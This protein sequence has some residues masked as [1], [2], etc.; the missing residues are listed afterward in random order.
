MTKSTKFL[1]VALVA[2]LA[3]SAAHAWPEGHSFILVDGD[4]FEIECI[5]VTHNGGVAHLYWTDM[6][7]ALTL[8]QEHPGAGRTS[9]TF[10]LHG[11]KFGDLYMA[12]KTFVDCT[13]S[14]FGHPRFKI[15][16]FPEG[17]GTCTCTATYRGLNL[18]KK[19][20]TEPLMGIELGGGATCQKA[21]A[22]PVL[23]PRV[24]DQWNQANPA[25]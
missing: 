20:R 9:L 25:R 14:R 23:R 6:A 11:K 5:D 7:T 8:Q 19:A 10:K 12:A 2:F 24:Q 15:A 1:A 17:I 22:K 21:Y 4:G 3:A 16:S 18:G 13:C